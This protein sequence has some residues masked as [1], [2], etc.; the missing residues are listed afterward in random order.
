MKTFDT[1]P[2][3][4]FEMTVNMRVLTD[5]E[6]IKS[7]YGVGNVA[8]KVWKF[9]LSIDGYFNCQYEQFKFSLAVK[10]S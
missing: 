6:G 9:L 2:H 10:V 3:E 1:V 4:S 7:I 8:K 5:L